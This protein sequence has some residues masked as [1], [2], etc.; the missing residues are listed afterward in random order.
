MHI[1]E[2]IWAAAQALTGAPFRLQ[3]RAAATGLDCVGLVA[4]VL[5][6]AGVDP[7]MVPDGYR[8]RGHAPQ[9]VEHALAACGLTR[10]DSATPPMTGDIALI[11]VARDQPHLAIIGRDADAHTDTALRSIHAHAGLRRVVETP[12]LPDGRLLSL[13]RAGPDMIAREEG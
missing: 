10:C 6:R 9:R 5:R 1:G 3:G 13:W 7:G 8:L 2:R 4:L 12:G 11:A